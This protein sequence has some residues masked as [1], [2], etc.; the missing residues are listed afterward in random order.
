MSGCGQTLGIL[1]LFAIGF[2][3]VLVASIWKGKGCA[4]YVLLLAT[5]FAIWYGLHRRQ[6]RLSAQLERGLAQLQKATKDVKPYAFHAYPYKP[7]WRGN[8]VALDETTRNIHEFH[9][10]MPSDYRT[11][12]ATKAQMVALVDC[13]RSSVGQYHYRMSETRSGFGYKWVCSMKLID[14]QQKEV[15]AQERF[16]GSDPPNVSE[17]SGD[18]E[19]DKPYPQM[20]QYLETLAAGETQAPSPV[21]R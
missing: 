11:D 14:L 17:S 15:V 2:G 21:A 10:E 16:E 5:P 13:G 4:I 18:Q 12:D 3:G 7:K 1:A 6:Q 8:V 9:F 20:V 19:G